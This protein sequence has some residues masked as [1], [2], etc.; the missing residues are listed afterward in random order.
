MSQ[1]I[2]SSEK[3]EVANLMYGL[4]GLSRRNEVRVKRNVAGLVPL[5]FEVEPLS[6][7]SDWTDKA[8]DEAL[9]SLEAAQ[10]GPS[11]AD[12]SAAVRPS[13]ESL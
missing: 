10:C 3:R 7:A 2:L 9:D 5:A 8:G 4:L 12:G 1:R 13:G 6:L 11:R